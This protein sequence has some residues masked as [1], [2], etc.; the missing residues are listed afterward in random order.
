[1]E[2]DARLTKRHD[3]EQCNDKG[4]EEDY[5][6]PLAGKSLIINKFVGT[7]QDKNDLQKTTQL[8]NDAQNGPLHG[9]LIQQKNKHNSGTSHVKRKGNPTVRPRVKKQTAIQ[10][11]EMTE[12]EKK[13]Q[14]KYN[15]RE[16]DI[17]RTYFIICQARLTHSLQYFK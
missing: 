5:T 6:E 10:H 13:D 16:M 3:G 11:A 15:L 7:S 8:R 4:S 9:P 1:M 2:K 17:N 14:S 12:N